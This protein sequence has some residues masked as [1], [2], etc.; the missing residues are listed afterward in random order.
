VHDVM[1]SVF[2]CL[3]F[4][5]PCVVLGSWGLCFQNSSLKNA[6]NRIQKNFAKPTK[7]PHPKP[8]TRSATRRELFHTKGSR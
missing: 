6:L 7:L 8:V 5:L 1:I 4:L 2:G 3:L